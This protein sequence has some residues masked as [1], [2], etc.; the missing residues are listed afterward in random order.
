MP[1]PTRKP[2]NA[3][4]CCARQVNPEIKH[5]DYDVS[6]SAHASD[7]SLADRQ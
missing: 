6:L 5:P 1:S 2:F 7:E 4:G 3:D